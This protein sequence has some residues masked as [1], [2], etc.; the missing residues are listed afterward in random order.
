[1]PVDIT[2]AQAAKVFTIAAFWGISN[3]DLLIQ[4]KPDLVCATAQELAE[5][6]ESRMPS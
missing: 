4:V 3:H 2:S 5:Y 6:S 1:M